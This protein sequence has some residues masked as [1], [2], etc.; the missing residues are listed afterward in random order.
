M[1]VQ[2]DE[3]KCPGRLD[4][5]EMVPALV[6]NHKK[7]PIHAVL[8]AGLILVALECRCLVNK[9]TKYVFSTVPFQIGESFRLML[10]HVLMSADRSVPG[11]CAKRLRYMTVATENSGKFI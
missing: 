7:D 4:C 2:V 9:Y 10:A 8:G 5:T 11:E 1:I 3:C 6:A